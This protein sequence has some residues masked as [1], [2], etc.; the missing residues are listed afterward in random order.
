MAVGELI[1][2]DERAGLS[3]P[4]SRR[5]AGL[6][7]HL[8]GRRLKSMHRLT[9]LGWLW[10][11]ARQL[12]QLA[13]LVV[14]FSHVLRLG[15]TNYP[16]FVF[17]GLL[18]WNWFQSGL[19]IASTSFIADRHLVFSP[20]LPN[21]VLPLAAILVPLIDTLMAMPVLVV[22]LAVTGHL[23][24]TI[25]L[26][27]PLLVVLFIFIG[28]LG[29]LVATLN[30]FVRDVENIV[31]VGL[32]LLFY[33]TPVFYAPTSIPAGFRWVLNVNPMAA[34]VSAARA[35]TL[36]GTLPTPAEA[37][38]VLVGTVL[39]GVIGTLVYRR[40]NGDLIDQL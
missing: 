30:V 10:P 18:V 1:A 28:G 13:V 6:V 38:S 14:V 4:E 7:C 33:L 12:V 5:L 34:A 37:V 8:A 2:V 39:A 9:L 22:A 21:G 26:L 31:A 40:L 29:L 25:L 36:G 17:S 16:L 24:P 19:L 27:A 32:I 20:R 11:L 35:V 23:R 3:W 15:I